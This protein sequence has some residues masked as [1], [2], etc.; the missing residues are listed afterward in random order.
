MFHQ[1]T[2]T[3]SLVEELDKKI[4]VVLRDGRKYVGIL[5][6][7][8]QFANVVMEDTVERVFVDNKYGEKDIGLFVVRGENVTLIG[9]LDLDKEAALRRD[10]TIIRVTKKE[11]PKLIQEAKKRQEEA[12]IIQK[13]EEY[14]IKTIWV[15]RR[16]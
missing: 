12:A 1:L 15:I 7:F 10:K 11:T 3:T 6:S 14:S 13:K 5:R 8:D 4:L 16:S 9:E 2:A